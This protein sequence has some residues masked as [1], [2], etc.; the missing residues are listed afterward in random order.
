MLLQVAGC[1]LHNLPPTF[2]W[3]T[4]QQHVKDAFCTLGPGAL[5]AKPHTTQELSDRR[6]FMDDRISRTDFPQCGHPVGFWQ[7]GLPEDVTG[8]GIVD[9][10]PDPL[11]RRAT[12][13]RRDSD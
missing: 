8:I 1:R 5:G 3:G 11:V 2:R 6:H 9:P 12:G 4:G 13:R 7:L 10:C